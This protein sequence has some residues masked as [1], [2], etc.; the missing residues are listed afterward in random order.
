MPMNYTQIALEINFQS[1]SKF[2]ILWIR[3]VAFRSSSRSNQ[4]LFIHSQKNFLDVFWGWLECKI[5][6]LWRKMLS[7]GKFYEFVIRMLHISLHGVIPGNPI[8]FPFETLTYL[9]DRK[10]GVERRRRSEVCMMLVT[11]HGVFIVFKNKWTEWSCMVHVKSWI[12]LSHMKSG[13]LFQL[14]WT[15]GEFS[16]PDEFS[17]KMFQVF[18]IDVVCV[19]WTWMSTLFVDYKW[20]FGNSALFQRCN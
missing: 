9:V 13:L 17:S 14:K 8:W 11:D 18:I 19:E 4:P 1:N 5:I 7:G 2:N 3:R 6:W 16:A 20:T 15:S 10:A 12:I